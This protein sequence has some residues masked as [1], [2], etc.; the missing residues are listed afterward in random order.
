MYCH[1]DRIVTILKNQDDGQT[2]R[3]EWSEGWFRGYFKNGNLRYEWKYI[4]DT[5]LDNNQGHL[6]SR[7][8]TGNSLYENNTLTRQDGISRS[9]Y[10]NGQ[11]KCEK[12]WVDGRENGLYIEWY[13][14]GQKKR[15][16]ENQIN[17]APDGLETKWYENGQK[18]EE[19]TWM[20]GEKISTKQWNEEGLTI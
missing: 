16:I 11:I 12:N 20:D 3:I 5:P 15:H 18:K 6:L 14:N 2:F 8:D 4:D 1:L 13:P 9:W 10:E 19:M 7:P 17:G